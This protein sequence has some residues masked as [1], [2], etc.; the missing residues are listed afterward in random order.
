[1]V[2][3][4]LQALWS[5]TSPFTFLFGAF[6][7]PH[8]LSHF[9]NVSLATSSVKVLDLTSS[10]S[11]VWL[12]CVRALESLFP[13]GSTAAAS[14]GRSWTP[15][16]IKCR[17]ASPLIDSKTIL[18]HNHLQLFNSLVS[19]SWSMPWMHPIYAEITDI[20]HCYNNFSSAC[21]LNF[22]HSLR[23]NCNILS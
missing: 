23:I 8:E 7:P 13:T 22:L 18:R 6:P 15:L 3:I 5:D 21:I 1:M 2:L 9:W 17:V 10:F 19:L 14:H 4:N 20:S 16:R 11:F 12:L